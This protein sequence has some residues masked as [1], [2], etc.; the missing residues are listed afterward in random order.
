MRV[1]HVEDDASISRAIARM[2]RRWGY[3]V[4][5]ISTA[6]GA[7][8]LLHTAPGFFDVCLSDFNLAG[9]LD[10][11]AVRNA[12]FATGTPLLFLTSDDRATGAPRLDKPCDMGE[13]RAAIVSLTNQR[14]AA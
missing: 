9:V 2:L 12:C 14:K 1:L 6:E 8:H 4:L 13:L 10:G 11:S 7:S 5:T 3:E